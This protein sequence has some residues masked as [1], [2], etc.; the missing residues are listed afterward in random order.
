[1]SDDTLTCAQFVELVTDYLEG[2]LDPETE[3]RF[4]RHVLECPGCDA[5]LDQFRETIRAIGRIEP[6]TVDPVAL[7]RL[8]DAFRGWR[9]P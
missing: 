5:Y 6:E 8:L 2:S 7:A 1:M 3:D 4:G 9:M